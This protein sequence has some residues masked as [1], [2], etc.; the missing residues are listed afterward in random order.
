M[1]ATLGKQPLT[2]PAADTLGDFYPAVSPD[3]R[4][5]AFARASSSTW[6]NMDVWVQPLQ[7]GEPRRLTSG[8][9][10]IWSGV[11]W[12]TS[13][14][15]ILFTVGWARSSL[16]R[17]RLSGGEP[18]PVL[19]V[20]R[21]AAHASVRGTRMVHEQRTRLPMDIW[22]VPRRTRAVTG[23]PPE[24]LIGSSERDNNPAYSPD[25][26]RIAFDSLR[27]GAWNVWLCDAD[28]SNLVQ[29][30]DFDSPSG[31][32]RWSP[33]GRRIVFD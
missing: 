1:L 6:G 21:H 33:D 25:G 26:P 29:L 24:K 16:L 7:G 22:R 2:S 28:G 20:G 4:Q 23:Q 19:G 32:P 12:T 5:V 13:G 15:E 10:D 3:G 27:S 11:A 8:Q 31:T 30:T 17:V 18:Q 9:Y 14:D